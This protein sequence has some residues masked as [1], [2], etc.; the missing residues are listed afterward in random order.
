MAFSFKNLL[1]GTKENKFPS[2]F[3]AHA[4]SVH[5]STQ[6]RKSNCTPL[7]V[8]QFNFLLLRHQELPAAGVA[9][10]R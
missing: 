5:L 7:H 6:F 2:D 10:E 9:K 1:G 4:L 3:S 8:Q